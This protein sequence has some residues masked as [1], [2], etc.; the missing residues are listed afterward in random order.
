MMNELVANQR[1]VTT[2]ELAPG[3]VEIEERCANWPRG[4]L[5]RAARRREQLAPG[6]VESSERRCG[7]GSNWP[8][9]QLEK[10]W[11]RTST[12]PR[13]RVG[14]RRPLRPRNGDRQLPAPR[15]VRRAWN[16]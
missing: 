2:L 6:P 8:R 11:A 3:P 10:A 14:E 5:E 4:L 7:S 15:A 9:G 16:A 13:A 12:A 1:R